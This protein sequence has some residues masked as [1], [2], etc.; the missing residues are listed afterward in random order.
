LGYKPLFAHPELVRDLIAHFTPFSA[1]GALDAAAFEQVN[2]A[3]VSERFTERQDDLVWRA[4]C[5]EPWL[6]IYIL[7][8]FQSRSDRWMALR[9]QV[10]R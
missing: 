10:P 9:M 6:Y 2:P 5:G 3:Y 1:L 7:L 4:R 8:A